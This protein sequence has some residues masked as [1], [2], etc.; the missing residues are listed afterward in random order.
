MCLQKDSSH[1]NIYDNLRVLELKRVLAQLSNWARQFETSFCSI[2][3][4][5]SH[6]WAADNKTKSN[7]A[8]LNVG[9]KLK[10]ILP[11]N[12]LAIQKHCMRIGISIALVSESK[13]DL[14]FQWKVQTGGISQ[15]QSH[16]NKIFLKW[17]VFSSSYVGC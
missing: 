14:S 5:H 4:S 9:F 12:S 2:A 10:N 11:E 8:Q 6:C 13:K 16:E 1:G 15:P 3:K 7:Q 17:R